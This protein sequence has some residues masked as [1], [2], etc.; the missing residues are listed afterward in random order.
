MSK[1]EESDSD[2]L[3]STDLLITSNLKKQQNHVDQT[4]PSMSEIM[5]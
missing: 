3:F 2:L 4:S 5:T 1:N